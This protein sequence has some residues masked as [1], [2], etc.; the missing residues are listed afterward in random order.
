M[1]KLSSPFPWVGGKR[2]LREQIIS[3][4]P[5]HTCYVEAFAGGAWVYW[6]K[7]P[8]HVEVI[9][10]IN[11]DLVN[12]YRQIQSNPEAFY[13]RL[14]WLLNSREE[15]Y[16]LLAIMKDTPQDLPDLDR[17]LDAVDRTLDF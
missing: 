11:G 1:K 6:G 4:I 17:V 14:W 16:R 15:Y 9:N 8:S 5:E 2:L 12:L 7:D 3:R 10:D 13:E